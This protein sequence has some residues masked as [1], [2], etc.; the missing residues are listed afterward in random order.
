MPIF[1]SLADDVGEQMYNVCFE[2]E[3][4]DLVHGPHMAF[5]SSARLDQLFIGSCVVVEREDQVPRFCSGILAELPTLK[6][7]QRLELFFEDLFFYNVKESL[8]TINFNALNLQ[9]PGIF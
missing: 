5:G 3:K 1:V 6:N 8:L 9:V 4:T 7:K 2:D